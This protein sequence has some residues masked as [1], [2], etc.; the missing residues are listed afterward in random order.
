MNVRDDGGCLVSIEELARLVLRQAINDGLVYNA[1]HD[2]GTEWT[3]SE[4]TGCG[5]VISDWLCER[6][7]IENDE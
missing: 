5:N 7:I 6:R 2:G 1:D 3:P 4:M